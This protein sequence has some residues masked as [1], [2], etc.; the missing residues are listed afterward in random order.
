MGISL[1]DMGAE[2]DA[3]THY[4]VTADTFDKYQ[5]QWKKFEA[6]CKGY[7]QSSLPADPRTVAYY[8]QQMS[9]KPSETDGKPLGISSFRA[10]CNAINFFHG[11]RDLQS[12]T[13][14]LRVLAMLTTLR[15]ERP[16]DPA[17]A[18]PLS[19]DVLADIRRTACQPRKVAGD[20]DKYSQFNPRK[21]PETRAAAVKRGLRETALC[22]L[23]SYSGMRIGECAALRWDSIRIQENGTAALFLERTKGNRSRYTAIP[24]HVVLDLLTIQNGASPSDAVFRTRKNR[25]AHEKT[26]ARWVREAVQATGRST[27][28]WS[29]HSGR[30]AAIQRLARNNCP[31]EIRNNSLGWRGGA[32]DAMATYYTR[33][34][35]CFEV[36][37]YMV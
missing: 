19:D 34:I 15:R 24:H 25:G 37:K 30:I 18:N 29:G 7:G 5:R 3:V 36:L 9:K 32:S 28:G 10:A 22:T 26:L 17:Q 13:H 23:L 14:D 33:E 16:V 35:D 8:I 20:R 27:K 21:R 12:P 2:V 6:A 11:L 1:E 31:R 4:G